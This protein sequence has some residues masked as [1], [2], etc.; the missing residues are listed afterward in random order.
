MLNELKTDLFTGYVRLGARD[1]EGVVLLDAGRVVNA[2]EVVKSE[3]RNGAKAF[4]GV[5]AKSRERDGMISVFQLSTEMTNLL[6]NLS[7]SRVLYK[8]LASD[9]TSLDRVI[10]G[11][12]GRH[13]SGYI[14]VQLSGGC[15]TATIFMREGDVLEAVLSRQG[16]ITDGPKVLDDVVRAAS[17]DGATF[18]VYGVQPVPR[19]AETKSAEMSDRPEHVSLWQDVLKT[20]ESGVDAVAKPGTFSTAFRR[21]CVDLA[22]SYPFL[23]PFAA[24]FEYREGQI[25]YDGQA[26]VAELNQ[27]L[28]RCLAHCVRALAAQSATKDAV[29][30]LS[31]LGGGLKKRHG[32]RLTEIGV[33]EAL[34]EVFGT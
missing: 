5:L 34:P 11:L 17:R 2:V 27:G 6:A 9:L 1:Y 25:R 14:D 26:G 16:T 20:V 4:D 8:D 33:A 3:R 31:S 24:E 12:R 18:T 19:E 13:H 10:A 23:D 22:D 21:A 30:R 32:Q 15:E 7:G 28:S 29:A